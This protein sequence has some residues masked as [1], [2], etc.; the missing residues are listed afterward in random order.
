[1]AL[2]KQQ[3]AQLYQKRSR[4]YDFT[5]NL[6]Y[7]IGFR[8]WAYRKKAVTAL[9]L[10]PGDTAVEVGCGTGL[11]FSLL[12]RAVGKQGKI[13]GVD[14]TEAMLFAARRR[15]ERNAWSNISLTQADVA[16][17]EFPA[18]INGV[19][20]TFALTLSPDYDDVILRSAEALAPGGRCVI[21][22]LKLPT[23]WSGK[24]LPILLPFFRPFG[25]TADLAD[26]RPWESLERHFEEATMQEMYFGYTYIATG[27]RHT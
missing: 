21:A 19:I 26:R 20:S 23:G 12:Q 18:G 15:C 6:Y 3:I 7:L 13:I 10:K 8:E 14:L 17:Y 27:I 11:N 5:A 1:V 2:T 25:V 4:W 16:D 24:V 9:N 22:D